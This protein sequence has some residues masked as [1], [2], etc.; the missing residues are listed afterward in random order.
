MFVLPTNALSGRMWCLAFSVASDDRPSTGPRSGAWCLSL[1]LFEHSPPTWI[2][3]R[4]LIKEPFRVSSPPSP[5]LIDAPTPEVTS[6]SLPSPLL[7]V[8]NGRFKPKPTITLRLKSGNAQL[9]PPSSASPGRNRDHDRQS[10]IVIS[11]DDSL[12]GSSLQYA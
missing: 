11:L 5:A 2:D 6:P 4:L 7:P 3:S 8:R 9:T 10:Q 12:M 1:S